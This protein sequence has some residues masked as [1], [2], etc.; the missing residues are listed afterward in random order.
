MCQK[1]E[2]LYVILP[3]FNFCDFKRRRELFI[4]FVN[5]MKKVQCI[6]VV[7]S[8]VVGENP[9]PKRLSVFRHF[10][11]TTE[12]QIWLKENLIN[13]AVK[14]L[15]DDW[16]SFAWIDADV[17]FLNKNWVKET[18]DALDKYDIVQ[19][20]QTVVNLGPQNEAFKIDKSFGYM[21]VE[22]G[23]K[24]MSNDKYGFW[25]PG[26]AWAC[27]RYTWK[28]FDGLIQWAI[29]GSA[30][31]HMAY[32]LL[33]RILESAPGNVHPSYKK[34]LVEFEKRCTGLSLGYVSGTILHHWHGSMKNRRYRERWD[35]L[36]TNSYDPTKDVTVDSNG[37]LQL[38]P[39]G[40][41]MDKEFV[42]YFTG[43]KEDDQQN[44]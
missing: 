34:L 19:L 4:Q 31:R 10:K 40:H 12:S 29:L 42:T 37:I 43:R 23:T 21:H 30:D 3:Y 35:I 6:R 24:L 39:R 16:S 13:L 7:I 1:K 2:F 20:F 44:Q 22:S 14:R 27:T 17:S 11:Y 38:T 18:L 28:R 33:G 25:H 9:L 32:A 36:T 8:E 26:Y 41:R 5:R 15:P